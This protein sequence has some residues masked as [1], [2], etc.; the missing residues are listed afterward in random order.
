LA[1]N[2]VTQADYIVQDDISSFVI[3]TNNF[4]L[5]DVFT[6]GNIP[7]YYR[8]VVD[9]ENLPRVGD[10][11]LTIASGYTLV[12]VE[13]L[14]AFMQPVEKVPTSLD[15]T[16]GILYNNLLSSFSTVNDYTVYYVRYVIRQG[17]STS[18]FVELLDNENTYHL[19]TFDDLDESM[20]IKEGRKAYLIEEVAEGFQ[21]T[22]PE[23]GTYAWQPAESALIRIEA[24]AQKTSEDPWYAR[25]S[26]GHFFSNIGGT[27]YEYHIAEFLSQS[28]TPEPPIKEVEEE[29]STVLSRSLIKLDRENIYESTDLGIYISLHISDK[30]DIAVSALTTDPTLDGTIATNGKPYQ[31]WDAVDQVGIRSVDRRTGIVDV[32]GL[33]LKT[34]YSVSSWYHFSEEKYEYTTVDLN[35]LDDSDILKLR[36]S[37]FVDPDIE[38]TDKEQTLYYLKTDQVGRV[39]ESNWSDF[40][41]TSRTYSGSPLFYELKP[42]WVPISGYHVFIDEFTTESS[43]VFLVLG[44]MTVAS[45]SDPDSL[46][47][48]DARR[49][50]GGI[51]DT[52]FDEALALNPEVQWYW[53]HGRWDGIPYPGTA[54]YL[55]EIPVEVLD[56]AGGTFFTNEIR[57]VVE[58]H[59][60]FGI[61]PVAHGYGVDVTISGLQLSELATVTWMGYNHQSIDYSVGYNLYHST[62]A[63]GP[64]TLA[65]DSPIAHNDFGHSY[66]ISGLNNGTTYYLRIV[67]G[68]IDGD[69]FTAL[70][71]QHIGPGADGAAG[72]E[73]TSANTILFKQFVADKLSLGS[74]GHEFTISSIV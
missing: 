67:G 36:T 58:E 64:W 55:V 43:G 51:I 3:E 7:I 50:G 41:N 25:V 66:S 52:L 10:S 21:V 47:E 29:E 74:L 15:N 8:H 9:E 16:K 23:T 14:D 22:L 26:N 46:T 71:T 37:I 5:T 53:D 11:D 19:A 40:D 12:E 35:P 44:D 39:I 17:S 63:D 18:T 1:G 62:S 59:T 33:K 13:L 73:S 69:D 4:L 28:F 2:R 60:G 68:I 57:D 70:V 20:K 38:S 56:G 48:L 27:I 24:P 49:R 30:N 42:D 31:R 54:C 6:S 34:T 65:N 32:D 72:I 61:Y 45:A